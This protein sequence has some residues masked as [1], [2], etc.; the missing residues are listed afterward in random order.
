MA[1]KPTIYSQGFSKIAF[2]MF[3]LRRFHRYVMLLEKS[4]KV[5]G[6]R[7]AAVRDF[8][9]VLVRLQMSTKSRQIGVNRHEH[10]LGVFQGVPHSASSDY[11][12]QKLPKAANARMCP[13]FLRIIRSFT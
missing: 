10:L 11:A 7:H 1:T 6:D 3:R 4:K 5:I 2:D 12:K 9:L 8:R 13:P